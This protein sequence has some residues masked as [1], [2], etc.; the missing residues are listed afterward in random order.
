MHV[1]TVEEPRR[2][3]DLVRPLLMADEPRHNLMLGIIGTLV[4]H[5]DVHPEFHLWAVEDGGRAVAAASMTPPFNLLVCRPQQVGALAALAGS[6]HRQGITLPGVTGAVPEVDGFVRE[7][8]RLSGA[9]A[10]RRMA[11]GVYRLE[12]VRAGGDVAG[13]MRLAVEGDRQLLMSWIQD[14]TAEALDETAVTR[15]EQV[16]G[17]RLRGD[18]GFAFWEDDGPVS[19]AGWGGET[20]NG[21]RIGP[22]YTPPALRGR[23]YA[24]A[25]VSELSARLLSE[26]RRFCFLYTNLANPVA[27]RLYERVGYE[28]VCESIDYELVPEL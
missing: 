15:S 1:V 13:R 6:I 8:T 4:T 24:G 14:F 28:R 10:R 7:W 26:G 22:V 16:V 3:V 25:L 2:F 21:V 17:R 12:S 5:P 19:L 9:T 27:N 18:G 23:G 11:Q 20:P